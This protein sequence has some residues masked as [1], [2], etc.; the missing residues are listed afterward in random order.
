MWHSSCI[1]KITPNNF[2]YHTKVKSIR[3]FM[4]VC[5]CHILLNLV[6]TGR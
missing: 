4:F 1:W 2:E 6:L 5:F 3:N